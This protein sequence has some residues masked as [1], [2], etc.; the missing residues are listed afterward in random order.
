MRFNLHTILPPKRQIF[1]KSKFLLKAIDSIANVIFDLR[2]HFYQHNLSNLQLEYISHIDGST[3]SFLKDQQQQQQLFRRGKEE[4][5]WVIQNPWILS[6][7]TKDIDSVKYHFSSFDRRFEFVPL[8]IFN[9]ENELVAF[10]LFARRNNDL[11]LPYCYYNCDV[12][13]I[14]KVIKHHLIKWR[15]STFTTFHQPLA[16]VL[17]EADVYSLL[18]REMKRSYIISKDFNIDQLEGKPGIQDGDG[19]CSFT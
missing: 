8:K 11:K 12:D 17:K 13:M 14:V 6:S 1:Q 5:N 10:L 15:I 16:S 18:K 7:A 2:F 4:L 19:D 3:A 9:T